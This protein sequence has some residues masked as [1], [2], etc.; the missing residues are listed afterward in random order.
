MAERTGKCINYTTCTLAYRNQP[1]TV[2]GDFV[3]PECGKPLQAITPTKAAVKLQLP[4]KKHLIIAGGVALIIVVFLLMS[5]GGKKTANQQKLKVDDT[6]L[7]PQPDTPPPSAAT[8]TPPTEL[9]QDPSVEPLP[10]A[11]PPPLETP[12]APVSTPEKVNTDLAV[13]ENSKIREEV[14]K[15]I[16]QMPTLTDKER[17]ALYTHVDRARGMGKLITIPFDPGKVTIS[18]AAIEQ[19]R[20]VTQSPEVLKMTSDPTV[21]F[22]VLGFADKRGDPKKNLQVSTARAEAVVK[23]LRERCGLENLMHS[24]GMGG[25][26][27]FEQGDLAKN[28]VTEVW[29][30]LP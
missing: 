18:A 10:L 2:T 17:D 5:G 28:R 3:C 19:L 29:A 20:K 23:V 24:V 6:E 4:S 21:V 12:T 15:R 9:A 25:S 8:P 11:T 13:T 27:F 22:V 16:D 26:E 30:V 1:I 14:L 7:A